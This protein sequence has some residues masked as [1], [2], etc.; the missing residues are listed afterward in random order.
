MCDASDYTIGVVLGGQCFNKVYRTIYYAS[1]T[2]TE[3]QKNYTTTE[4]E[5]LVVV[6]ALQKFKSYLIGTKVSIH[7]DHSALK[8]LLE[9]K[10]AKLRLICWVLLLEEFNIEIQDKKG[11]KNVS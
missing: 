3:N 9:K 11:S 7:I 1:K 10:N 8:Y 5:L 4:N 2:L 6:Y